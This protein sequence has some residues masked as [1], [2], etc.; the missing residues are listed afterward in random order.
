[1]DNRLE[2]AKNSLR[3]MMYYYVVALTENG[4]SD[5]K[6]VIAEEM[7]EMLALTEEQTAYVVDRVTK[8]TPIVEQAKCAVELLQAIEKS[9]KL[10]KESI[11]IVRKLI[12]SIITNYNLSSVVQVFS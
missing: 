2:G 12:E 3:T 1:M 6:K 8:R 9:N 10:D 4:E 11:R 7:A 5:P